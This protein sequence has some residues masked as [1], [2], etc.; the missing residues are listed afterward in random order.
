MNTR[1]QATTVAGDTVEAD[2]ATS[3]YDLFARDLPEL[4]GPWMTTS[5][6]VETTDG[7]PTVLFA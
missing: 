6:N 3:L 2:A 5:S 7:D 4:D 1:E